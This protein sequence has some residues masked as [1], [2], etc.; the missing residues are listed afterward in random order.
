MRYPNNLEYPQNN[1]TK[2]ATKVKVSYMSYWWILETWRFGDKKKIRFKYLEPV[3]RHLLIGFTYLVTCS[4]KIAC[5]V[6][7]QKS[8]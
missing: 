7:L 6:H 3:I 1:K 4:K 2:N 5:E 8:Q